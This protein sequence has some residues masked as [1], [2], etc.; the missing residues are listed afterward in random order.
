MQPGSLHSSDWQILF[1][2]CADQ[3]QLSQRHAGL[4]S[5]YSPENE[6]GTN[7]A[8]IIRPGTANQYKP[9]LNKMVS[10]T[11]MISAPDATPQIRVI[12]KS[13]KAAVTAPDTTANH[14]YPG[15][16]PQRS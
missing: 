4:P 11:N 5:Q 9:R 2:Q 15:G 16:N 1:R 13:K 14:R 8:M 3:Y 6:A 12:G 10:V 7:A